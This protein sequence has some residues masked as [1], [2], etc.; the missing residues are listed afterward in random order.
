VLISLDPERLQ[1]AIETACQL[2]VSALKPGNVTVHRAG[3]GMTADDFLVS[4]AAICKPLTRK[5]ASIG[6]RIFAAVTATRSKVPFNTNLGIILLFAPIVHAAIVPDS[7]RSLRARVKKRLATLDLMDAELAFR[8]I[9]LAAPG[10]LGT[11]SR[12]DVHRPAEVTLLHAMKEAKGRDFV[13]RQY[14]NGYRDVFDTG[15]RT[16]RFA[17]SR[18]HSPEWMAVAVYLAYLVRFPDSLITRKFG[19][20]AAREVLATARLLES[21]LLAQES[22]ESMIPA[23]L[24]WDER[25]KDAGLNPGT[26][27]DLTA[28]TLLALKVQEML[29]N[30]FSGSRRQ[31]AAQA[32]GAFRS[33]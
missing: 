27:A 15:I 6:E 4:A 9:R 5:D 16:A 13:A 20:A 1:E 28:A 12:H 14:A 29:V 24:E 19:L 26:S 11:V 8:A 23:L 18:W 17:L 22:P 3:H 25:L 31:V 7:E 30:E 33:F 32:R 2:E 10:G 21:Q